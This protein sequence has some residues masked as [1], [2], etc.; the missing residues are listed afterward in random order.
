MVTIEDGAYITELPSDTQVT[1]IPVALILSIIPNIKNFSKDTACVG[2]NV[3]ENNM[4]LKKESQAKFLD[5][6]FKKSA[7]RLAVVAHAINISTEEA[8]EPL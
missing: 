5:H 1:G 6:F 7:I 4:N 2:E 8:S 3:S